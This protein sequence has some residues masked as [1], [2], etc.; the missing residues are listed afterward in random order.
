MGI[1]VSARPTEEEAGRIVK[2]D[3]AWMRD[4]P[5]EVIREFHHMIVSERL[6]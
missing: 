1:K 3:T 6:P 2:G 4:A 5:D